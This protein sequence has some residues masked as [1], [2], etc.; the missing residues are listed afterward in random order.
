MA[1]TQKVT[2][3]NNKF[4][5]PPV[6]NAVQNDTDR[7]IVATL[8]DFTLASGMTAKLSFER[9]DKTHYET[10][11]TVNTT[12]NT[13]TA[14]LDQALTQVG[15]CTAQIKVTETDGLGSTFT[16]IIKVQQD[17]AGISVEQDGWSAEEFN[18]RL[19]T[20]EQDIE[21]LAEEVDT[22]YAKKVGSYDNLSAGTA[23]GIIGKSGETDTVPYTYRAIPHDSTR[24]VMRKIVGATVGWNQLVSASYKTATITP[25]GTTTYSTVS[26]VG[27]TSK[28][29]HVYFIHTDITYNG[30]KFPMR[31]YCQ[32]GSS[33]YGRPAIDI[34]SA[35][36]KSCDWLAK[37]TATISQVSLG[38]SN[39]TTSDKLTNADQWKYDNAMYI[40]LTAMLGTAIADY[41]YSLETATAGAGVE[42]L[43]SHFPKAFN[44]YQ[45]YDAGSLKS[46]EGLVSHDTKDASENL[47]ASYP[48]DPTQELRGIFK[49]DSSNNLYADGDTYEADGTV[50]RKYG[51]LKCATDTFSISKVSTD[52]SNYIYYIPR[53]GVGTYFDL[54]CDKLVTGN[55]GSVAL[56]E[57]GGCVGNPEYHVIY[58]NAEGLVSQ[59]DKETVKQWLVN[60]S[61]EFVYK[62]ATPTESTAPAFADVQIIDPDGTE[63]FVTDCIVAVGNETF[64]ADD[65]VGK[66]DDLPALPTTAGT[67]RLKVTVTAGVPSYEWVTT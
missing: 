35:G 18:E 34:T 50:T 8:G 3:Y 33:D 27:F 30:S 54:S 63:E 59:N 16:F 52:A 7:Q 48:L 1:V 42:W 19:T 61:V 4:T 40:D 64:Y 13:V 25:D 9:P 20:A 51:T 65:L 29:N 32:V 62:L 10:T 46:V 2:L 23:S 26:G 28:A 24:E 53:P 5:V 58:V 12:N 31:A 55:S 14:E 45:P 15:I 21:D 39:I 36:G 6:I 37:R 22:D 67:Y 17:V 57:K 66:L 49:L 44:E 11:G 43:K 56:L 60:N 47:I 38:I 41:V